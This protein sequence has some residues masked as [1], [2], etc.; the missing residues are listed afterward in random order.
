MLG[1]KL[2]EASGKITGVRVLPTEGGK[3]KVEVSFQGSG[4]LMGVDIGDVGTYWQSIR[5]GGVLHG[6]GH[7]LMTTAD[8]GIA[9]WMGFG[10]GR[11]TGP[12]PAA[13][14]AVS[15][16]FIS[17]PTKLAHLGTI[18]TAIE[19][20]VDANGGYRWQMWEWK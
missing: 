9:D 18:V 2:G 5:E 7:V 6:E 14:Y 3:I 1:D 10:V 4:K 16:Q 17:V 19:Y 13:H 12:P 15:G 8:G 20:D 11:P